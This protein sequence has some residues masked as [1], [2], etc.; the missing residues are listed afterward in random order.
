LEPGF[1][2]KLFWPSLDAL[3]LSGMGRK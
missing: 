2:R 3:P 1:E